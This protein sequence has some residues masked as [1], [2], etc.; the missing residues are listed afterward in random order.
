MD[1]DVGWSAQHAHV[2][3]RASC[4]AQAGQQG[5]KA[6]TVSESLPKPK[7]KPSGGTG[8]AKTTG[9]QS[10]ENPGT[11]RDRLAERVTP[12]LDLEGSPGFRYSESG[13]RS[14]SQQE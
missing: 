14:S 10:P 1:A 3:E 4:K 7:A 13:R 6:C 9:P 5:Q 8:S 12:E 2:V 11:G